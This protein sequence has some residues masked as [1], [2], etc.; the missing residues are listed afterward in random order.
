MTLT[1]QMRQHLDAIKATQRAEN[2][3]D[4]TTMFHGPDGDSLL[5]GACG[6]FD[7]IVT[8]LNES[9]AAFL[10]VQCFTC[11]TVYK[12]IPGEVACANPHHNDPSG[13]GNTACWKH[14]EAA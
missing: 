5:C 6:N 9:D 8:K 11:K 12:W 14:P 4:R 1:K 2:I 7:Y 10:T 3:L 13:C